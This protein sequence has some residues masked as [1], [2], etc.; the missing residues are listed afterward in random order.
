MLILSIPGYPFLFLL[1]NPL[2]PPQQLWCSHNAY[3]LSQRL[4]VF[5]LF[6]VL[7]YTILHYTALHY[8]I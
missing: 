3:A 2:K 8:T 4:T 6:A 7:H 5:M 1:S